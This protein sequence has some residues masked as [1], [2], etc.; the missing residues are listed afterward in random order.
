MPWELEDLFDQDL[1]QEGLRDLHLLDRIAEAMTPDPE[2]PYGRVAALE[3][4]LYM[5][6]QLL[7]DS[8][9][10]GM[11][12][13]IEIR[14]PLVDAFLLQQLAPMLHHHALNE[15][16]KLLAQAP[17]RPIPRKLLDRRKT[18][19]QVPIRHWLEQDD[20]IDAWKRRPSL[21]R[22]GVNW[23]RRWAYVLAERIMKEEG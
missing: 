21:S 15:R 11:A 3:S 1:V 23:E 18:G 9:W 2:T 10:A 13:S 20:R 4:S 6:N 8:D 16:K 17:L 5:R 12:H 19:F 14:V 7:R 22:D